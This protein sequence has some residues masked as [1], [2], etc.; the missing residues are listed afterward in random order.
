MRW[1]QHPVTHKLV[2]YD[3]VDWRHDGTPSTMVI[4]D[5][6][7]FKSPVDGSIIVGRGSLREHNRRNGVENIREFDGQKEHVR[8]REQAAIQRDRHEAVVAAVIKHGVRS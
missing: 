7:E 4:G 5:I 1:V 3:E 6:E 8:R 2:P